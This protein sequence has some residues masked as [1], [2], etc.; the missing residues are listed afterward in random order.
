MVCYFYSQIPLKN[1][2]PNVILPLCG[3][4]KITAWT[5]DWT[6]AEEAWLALG[7]QVEAKPGVHPSLT[8]FRGWQ[9]R[10]KHLYSDIAS[11]WGFTS[12]SGLQNR[13][14]YSFPITGFWL[15]HFMGHPKTCQKE[16]HTSLPEK[17]IKEGKFRF[18]RG[19]KTLGKHG[20]Q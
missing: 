17:T 2:V 6:P 11:F 15:M 14:N 20:R 7:A 8:S 3:N 19:P 10:G 16:F 1:Y 4:C 18:M 12:S 5:S 9:L 13:V